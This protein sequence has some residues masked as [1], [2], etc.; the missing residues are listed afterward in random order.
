MLNVTQHLLIKLAEE[1]GEIAKECHKALLFGL[2]DRCT[3]DPKVRAT[4]GPTVRE[5]LIGEIND[6]VSVL[7]TLVEINVL[8]PGYIEDAKLDAKREKIMAYMDY[9]RMIG[10]LEPPAPTQSR[11]AAE[12]WSDLAG[13]D[14]LIIHGGEG[15][16]PSLPNDQAHP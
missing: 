14:S 6:L 13:A 16:I 1:A 12:S 4:E 10:E 5:K 7:N 11:K 9:A 8:Q 15:P 2:D 3:Y